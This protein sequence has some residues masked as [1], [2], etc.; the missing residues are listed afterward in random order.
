MHVKILL[1]SSCAVVVAA[2]ALLAACNSESSLPAVTTCL[3]GADCGG[4]CV[5]LTTDGANC[6]A[7]GVACATG[8]VCAAG[9]CAA[10]CA[11]PF[12]ACGS[13]VEAR[14]ADLRNDPASC[15]SCGHACAA[16]QLCAAGDCVGT[17]A[18]PLAV[19][20]DGASSSC[21]DL[22]N[23]PEH[24]GTCNIACGAGQSCTAGICGPSCS[25]PLTVCGA[26]D[27]ARCVDLRS[28]PKSCGSCGHACAAGEACFASTC[29]A[30]C[31]GAGGTLCDGAC[32][33]LASD[34]ANCGACGHACPSGTACHASA[35]E[36]TCPASQIPC[37]DIC[38]DPGSDPQNCGA[39][40]NTCSTGICRAG[41]CS[42]T[43]CEGTIG[44][45]DRPL[46]PPSTIFDPPI[47]HAIADLDG[48]GVLDM[49]FARA[50]G[51]V[52]E[53]RYVGA[54]GVF[55]PPVEL[56]VADH[57]EGIAGGDVDGDG[58]PD[59]VACSSGGAGAISLLR[60]RG[61][62]SFERTDFPANGPARFCAL[63]DLDGDGRPDLVLSYTANAQIAVAHNTGGGFAAPVPYATRPS[64]TSVALADLDGDGRLDVVVLTS[65]SSPGANTTGL[66]RGAVS[67][68]PGAGDGTLGAPASYA[69]GNPPRDLVVADLDSD[70]LLDVATIVLDDRA[71]AVLRNDGSGALLP[72]S[73]LSV[74]NVPI[75]LAAGDLDGDG[76]VDLVVNRDFAEVDVLRNDGHAVFAAPER[77]AIA[78]E[79]IALADANGD[80][81]L[82]LYSASSFPQVVVQEAGRLLAATPI[83][84]GGGRVTLADVDGDGI[85]DAFVGPDELFG[86]RAQILRGRADGSFDPPAGPSFLAVRPVAVG[87]I[88]GDGDI[89]VVYEDNTTIIVQRNRGDGSFGPLEHITVNATD[90]PEPALADLDGDGDLDLIVASTLGSAGS[91]KVFWNDGSGHFQLGPRLAIGN[92]AAPVAGK[93]TGSARRDIAVLDMVF[94]TV[95][96]FQAHADG[97]FAL[98]ATL[99]TPVAPISVLIADV[100]QDGRDD[101]II[102]GMGPDATFAPSIRI[103]PGLDHGLGPAIDLPTLIYPNDLAVAD[104]DSDGRRDLIAI[105]GQLAFFRALPGGGFAA[106]MMYGAAGGN[107]MAIRDLTGDLRPDVVVA[108]NISLNQ[109]AVLP[110]RCLAP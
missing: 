27:A 18:A 49:A 103:Y 90:F 5:Q 53:I 17:C 79:E 41:A 39:C 51:N 29:T 97:S 108:S 24:C 42:A 9:H 100:T 3:S 4:V 87:D 28:D 109:F 54:F 36:I 14:C 83:P 85:P 94:D 16:G 56:A 6:G 78:S 104:L 68:Y 47:D 55:G 71:V 13:G 77:Y 11:A 33:D 96:V 8:E 72:R 60:N 69:T 70:G 106:P 105:G 40:G 23:D 99:P 95:S 43:A 25:A 66:D 73:L 75:A 20:T 32:A 63:G 44:L 19:C 31:S 30:T 2:L 37:G 82:D 88:D 61:D 102:G 62:G 80:G 10:S 45:P 57:P 48:D 101:L 22:R 50:S 15:G 98:F 12:T 92:P 81:A 38:L 84:V 35:C 26:G 107:G 74:G 76:A 110:N 1:R 58:R 64:P 86:S 52:V 67:V 91:V 93:L 21:A 34:D 7:C 46:P 89:D 65:P 59:L